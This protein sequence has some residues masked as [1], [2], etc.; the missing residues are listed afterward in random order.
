MK[1]FF[2]IFS[3]GL[4]G[5][6]LFTQQKSFPNSKPT[7]NTTVQPPKLVVGIVVDQMR[8]DYIY[9]FW[10]KFGDGG[11]R[12]LINE[13]FF[14]RNTHYNYMPTETGPGHASIYTG[15][16]P[17]VHGIVAND[18]VDRFTGKDTVYCV[19]DY[20]QKSIGTVSDEGKRSPHLMLTTSICD[21]LRMSSRQQSKV[22]GIALKDRA[23]ILPAGH[24]VD[25]NRG[26]SAYWYEGES[27]NF[28]TSSYYMA[29][30]PDWINTF[31]AKKL[32]QQYLSE[33]WTTLLPIQDYTESDPDNT[34]Y[35]KPFSNESTP[36][37]PHR[38]NQ[39]AAETK[40]WKL[41][42][43][44]PF[45]CTLTKDL[46]LAAIE[47]EQLGKRNATDFLAISFSSPDIIGHQFGPTSI[48]I[49]DT[50]LRL[51]R[52]IADLLTFLD[53]WLGKKNILA[54]LTAD[55]G[56]VEVPQY[57]ID[58]HIPGGYFDESAAAGSIKKA[59]NRQFG[60]STLLL[61][62][63]NYQAFLNHA[64]IAERGLKTGDV[65]RFVADVFLQM[66][67]ITD[68]MTASMLQSSEF[69]KGARNLVQN[70]WQQKRSGDICYILA[71]GWLATTD[72][73]GTSHGSPWTYDTH[74]PLIWWGGQIKPGASDMHLSITDIAPTVCH[75]LNIQSPNGTTGKSILFPFN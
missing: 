40:K 61:K 69:N 13:G 22:I 41:I 67:G 21:Q 73:K 27:G 34:P 74:V 57:L 49:E 25:K 60:D 64:R 31:N 56:V 39:I 26:T 3:I 5:V 63:A 20:A 62:V 71:P 54:F 23:A 2:I 52:D 32:P 50:Y 43:N 51:D 29:Q 58:N 36:V 45:G 15:T 55:H 33:P 18:M 38:I 1:R 19:A 66:N 42:R 75:L 47:G 72:H 8:Y 46:A 28:I 14:C 37:F 24:L 59:L 65:E 44:S 68:V 48:E 53:T 12:R 10:N 17:S 4:V 16:V 6:L 9:R 11:F 30:L 35:E 70:G 7:L